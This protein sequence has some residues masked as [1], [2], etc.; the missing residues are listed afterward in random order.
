MYHDYSLSAM[1]NGSKAHKKT[2][3]STVSKE[4]M[5]C[6][7]K[8]GWQGREGGGQWVTEER[9]IDG[10]EQGHDGQHDRRWAT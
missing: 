6:A 3:R 8:G 4:G 7:V 10:T 1:N 5:L 2:L 9:R